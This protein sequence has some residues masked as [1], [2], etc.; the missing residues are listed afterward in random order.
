MIIGFNAGR[1][2][3][4]LVYG[5]PMTAWQLFPG[6]VWQITAGWG[7]LLLVAFIAGKLYRWVIRAPAEQ[8]VVQ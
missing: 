7:A 4:D 3:A 5:D 2:L 6:V 8:P 1:N